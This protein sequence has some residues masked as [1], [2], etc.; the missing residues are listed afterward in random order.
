MAMGSQWL[1]ISTSDTMTDRYH[2]REC[3]KYAKT[4]HHDV[5]GWL[6]QLAIEM[7][8]AI[9]EVQQSQGVEGPVC[10]IG[11]HHGRLFIL[12]HLLTITGQRSVGWDLFENQSL[13]VD[14]SGYGDAAVSMHN[15]RAHGGR[16][17]NVMLS[18]CNSLSL[19]PKVVI[20]QCK[21]RP[22]LFSVDGG[23]TSEIT[24]NDLAIAAESICN[25]GVVILDDY[26]N[27]EWPGV[28]QGTCKCLQTYAGKLFPFAVGGN[29]LL[30]TNN[31]D[32]ARVF[33]DRLKSAIGS[34]CRS[35]ISEMFG[36]PVVVLWEEARNWK[37]YFS[38]TVLWRSFSGTGFGKAVRRTILSQGW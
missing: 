2:S 38:N 21:G 7:L 28:S 22:R 12:L 17:E 36:T 37:Q 32:L 20:D 31:Q 34:H 14:Q 15:L 33:Q 26:F 25:G 10:E 6:E 24:S 30:F 3:Q 35:K 5:Q 27:Q 11:V 19:T 29:K 18:T 13:N 23:H 8:L 16:I 4:G 9:D 1:A